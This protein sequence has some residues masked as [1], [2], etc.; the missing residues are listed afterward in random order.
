MLSQVLKVQHNMSAQSLVHSKKTE[1]CQSA[2]L[3]TEGEGLCQ[4]IM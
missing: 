1:C 4:M 2:E 3:G